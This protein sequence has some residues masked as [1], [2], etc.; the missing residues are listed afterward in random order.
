VNFAPLAGASYAPYHVTDIVD[1]IGGGDSF[2]AALIYASL[3][4]ELGANDA[5]VAAFAAA[6][7]CLCHSVYG[8]FNYSSKS[9]VLTLMNGGTSGRIVR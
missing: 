7:S 5:R 8:D 4:A 3:D 2:G 6:A 1:R 9:E